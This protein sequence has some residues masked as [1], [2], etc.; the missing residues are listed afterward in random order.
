M[1]SWLYL[2]TVL[3]RILILHLDRRRHH[4]RLGVI[5]KFHLFTFFVWADPVKVNIRGFSWVHNTYIRE[6]LDPAV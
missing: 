1:A 2:S 3:N 4:Y 6:R 5:E